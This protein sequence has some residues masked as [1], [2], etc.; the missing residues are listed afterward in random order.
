MNTS[1]KPIDGTRKQSGSPIDGTQ[2]KP[3]Q[4]AWA[5]GTNPLTQRS[6]N[7][8]SLNGTVNTPKSSTNT[9]SAS[10]T[11]KES[12]T[13]DRHA[14]DRLL[15]L[16]ANFI[17][18]TSTITLK[19]GD[20]YSGI[21]S[22]SSQEN[23]ND[24]RYVLKMVRRLSS[25]NDQSNGVRDE[26]Y[27]GNG[28]E[29]VM[30]FDSHDVVDLSVA[31]VSIDK[32]S[33]TQN[34]SGGFKT[35]A[36]ISGNLAIRERN[37]QRWEPADSG[38]VDLS[39]ESS[40]AG[41]DQFEAN[42]RLYGVKSTFD[43]NIYTTKIDRT[44]PGYKQKE[45]DAERIAREINSSSNTN[46][47]IAEERGQDV[48]DDSGL[49]E[50]DK[51][52]GVRRGGAVSTGNKYTPPAR[53]APT[54]HPTVSGAPVDPAIIS[55]QIARPSQQLAKTQPQ[56]ES[57]PAPETAVK[58]TE[59]P[60]TVLPPKSAETKGSE[61]AKAPV[62]MKP[63][64]DTAQKTAAAPK[65]SGTGARRGENATQNVENE[66]LDSF[67]LFSASEK[68]RVQESQRRKATADKA[69][70][71]NDLKKFSQNFKLNTPVP[72]DLVPI[73]AKDKQKQEQI[74][75]KAL[76]QVEELKSTPPRGTAAAAPAEQRNQRGPPG[77]FDALPTSPNAQVDRQN[78]Q[79]RG[80]PNQP[81]FSQ[82]VRGERPAQQQN[83]NNVP[84]GQ[85][86]LSQRLALAQS[87]HK[88]GQMIA[89]NMSQAT[90]IHGLNIPPSGGPSAAT[91]GSHTPT[92]SVSTRFNVGA[93]E[94][95]PNPG[96]A[97]FNP[98]NKSSPKGEPA[99][100]PPPP[101][102]TPAKFFGDRKS[103]PPASRPSIDDAFNPVKRMKKE[104]S[105]N[106]SKDYS[107]ND[108]IPQAYRTHPTWDVSAKNQ[109]KTYQDMF[110]KTPLTVQSIS[111][112]HNMIPNGAMPHHHQLPFHLQHN[113][114]VMQ[115]AHT[116]NQTPR[117]VP[118]QPHHNHN[119]P[120]HFEGHPMQFS[121][122][123]TAHSSPRPPM[124]Q[125]VPY[126]TPQAQPVQM[127]PQMQGYSMSPNPQAVTIRQL[128]P[129]AQFVP[130]PQMGGQMMVS[131]P[132]NGPYMNMPP[133]QPVFMPSPGQG[134]MFPHNGAPIPTHQGPNGYP[135][136][137]PGGAPMMAHQGSQQGHQQVYF[138]PPGSHAPMFAHNPGVTPMRVPYAQQPQPQH[139]GTSPHQQHHYPQ[140][141][142]GTPS[143][144]YVQPMMPTHSMPPQVPPPSGPASHM[145]EGV[146]ESK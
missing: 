115:N 13:P 123:N 138:V 79:Q 47:H 15:F 71:L 56:V 96:A 107:M 81:N 76:R 29:H 37:L 106:P 45:A 4:K 61:P 22:G 27:I 116:P 68:L 108:G 18:L 51:Y 53:R 69:V 43:E 131:Q 130:G 57:K 134:H 8:P 133:G 142:R 64:A 44:V 128:P 39:L 144:N 49:D 75:E 141:H 59:A 84:R 97:S 9:K 90:S 62:P 88:Q 113:G 100:R 12:N 42:E 63:A 87:Q 118:A 95:R 48:I 46:A 114:P 104:E 25:A 17:G 38:N 10:T 94:F 11:S 85:G 31:S 139:Y 6:S 125:Y 7:S 145:Q 72:S 5:H 54:G 89:A 122:S 143:T 19:N 99:T 86:L 124:A 80:R 40:P 32:T 102:P 1:N 73:L 52:S 137:R 41:W 98:S 55:A 129:G 20:K 111:P 91:S 24:I 120:H 23:P 135:S 146:E 78:M 77:R 112:A 35:D 121:A 58:P 132:S 14:N 3:P 66:L 83:V 36:D 136:P 28:D 26:G 93:K 127:Y 110:D 60:K 65:L 126:G 92:S 2:R 50:E 117:H 105:E 140:Q 33:K 30:L 34:V 119:G 103:S 67:R 70:K 101:K 82:T 21:F 16:F 109:E 74:V